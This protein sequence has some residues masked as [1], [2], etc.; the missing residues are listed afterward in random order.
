[1]PASATVG[2]Q[3]TTDIVFDMTS[4]TVGA[5]EVF[6]VTV[7]RAFVVTGVTV[8]CEATQAGGTVTVGKAGAAITGA[9]VCATANDVVQA[10]TLAVANSTFAV[11]DQ[12]RVTVATAGSRGTVVVRTA[13]LALGDASTVAA[14]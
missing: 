7:T 14:V 6:N 13:P 1:M 9:L 5:S 4:S 8:I 11:G 12:L 3:N 10:T 2:Y